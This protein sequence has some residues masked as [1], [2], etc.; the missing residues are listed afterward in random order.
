MDGHDCYA[1]DAY[2]VSRHASIDMH[3]PLHNKR[4]HK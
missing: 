2:I 1:C 4:T 3:D